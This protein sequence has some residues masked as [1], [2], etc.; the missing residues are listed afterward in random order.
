MNLEMFTRSELPT[1]EEFDKWVLQRSHPEFGRYQNLDQQSYLL[2][3]KNEFENQN[4]LL[5]PKKKESLYGLSAYYGFNAI[6]QA[7]V[8]QKMSHQMLYDFNLRAPN[9]NG[10]MFWDTL[11]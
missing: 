6:L 4:G 1:E 3:K 10:L 8:A 5:V 11:E 9:I 2:K 7:G